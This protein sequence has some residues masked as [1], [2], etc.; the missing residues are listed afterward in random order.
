MKK[1]VGTIDKAV[2]YILAAVLVILVVTK[3]VTGVLAI[4]LVVL[5]A[6]FL[7]TGLVN[8]CPIWTVFGVTTDKK[9]A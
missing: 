7:L 2:R 6:V 9:K 8:Y 4:V 5:A 3:V 1:N